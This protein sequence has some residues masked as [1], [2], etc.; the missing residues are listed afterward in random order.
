VS[1]LPVLGFLTDY[2]VPGSVTTINAITPTLYKHLTKFEK[3]DSGQFAL[4]VLI[5]RMYLSNVMNL[6]ILALSY[7]LLADPFLLADDSN[8]DRRSELEIAFD[9]T[10]Y[11]CRLNAAAEGLFS[12][13]LSE[14]F[15]N[16]ILFFLVG[17]GPFVINRY[18]KPYQKFEMNIAP[19]MVA[20]LYFINLMMLAFPF[21]PLVA[22]F[23][24]IMLAI[25]LKWE[26][27]LTLKFYGKP[28]DIWQ[29]H[30]AGTFFVL[31]YMMSLTIV[32]LPALLLFLSQHTFAKT[33]ALQDNFVKLCTDDVSST[34]N[35][36]TLDTAS[37]YYAYYYN[38]NNCA[39][40][41]PACVCEYSCGPFVN[42][43][44]AFQP[45]RDAI[46]E[47]S[48][49]KFI[50]KRLIAP[51]YCAWWIVGFLYVFTRL[52]K[53]TLVVTEATFAEKERGYETQIMS[54]ENEK[55]QHTKLINR[56]KL[57]EK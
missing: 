11:Q 39:D 26:K 50:W 3:W 31:F 42:T 22:V 34:D 18:V 52:R 14:F 2:I 6:L 57:L 21:S 30:K 15:V 32:A 49:L 46:Y 37:K 9:P 47:F 7:G 17:F 25:R 53:N 8:S 27:F 56:L 5:S 44:N 43:A 13:V 10:A 28:K 38:S 45:L 51:S 29:A 12:L 55:K 41:Y 4:N 16:G 48:A 23:M 1:N 20:L 19:R 36:C 35:T 24:P 54:L 40:G 33:C